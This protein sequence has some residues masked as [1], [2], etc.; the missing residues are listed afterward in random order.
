MKLCECGCGKKTNIISKTC[1]KNGR[2]KGEYSRFYPKHHLRKCGAS[3]KKLNLDFIKQKYNKEGWSCFDIAKE[4]G[5]CDET[6]R[7]R[8]I[9]NKIERRLTYRSIRS[10]E[11]I[12]ENTLEQFRD[13]M[14]IETKMKIG[15]QKPYLRTIKHKIEMSE[16]ISLI[17]KEIWKNPE[18]RKKEIERIKMVRARTI[19]PSKDTSIEVKIQNFLKQLGIEFFTHQYIAEIENAYRCDIL[20]TSMKLV[21]ECDGNYWHGN[22]RIYSEEE[23]NERQKEQKQRDEKRTRQLIEKGYNVLRLWED[24]IKPMTLDKFREKL[25]GKI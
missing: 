20:I 1:K 17:K 18:F 11:K 5:V 12:R 10:R 21:L 9:E 4:L 6:I 13:G 8:L 7:S 25:H 24:E 3:R 2:I 19:I 16:K 23:L 14:P 22:P 15:A